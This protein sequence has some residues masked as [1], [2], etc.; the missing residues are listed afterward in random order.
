M[1]QIQGLDILQSALSA[2]ARID[3]LGD[4]NYASSAA[5]WS[6]RG[7]PKPGA[8]VNVATEGDVETTVLSSPCLRTSVKEPS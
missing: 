6:D 4:P 3:L 8:V 5:R 7:T 2:G 1:A